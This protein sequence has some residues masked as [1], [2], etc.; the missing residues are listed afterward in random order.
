M[1][2]DIQPFFPGVQAVVVRQRLLVALQRFQ[3]P[4]GSAVLYENESLPL[5]SSSGSKGVFNSRW[6]APHVT[7]AW[8]SAFRPKMDS[9]M[10]PSCECNRRFASFFCFGLSLMPKESSEQRPELCVATRSRQQYQHLGSLVRI[11]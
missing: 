7:P 6:Y 4:R 5:I 8:Q 1:P 10:I 2:I 3:L 11:S 9:A